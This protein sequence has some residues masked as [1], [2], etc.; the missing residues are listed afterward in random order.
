MGRVTLGGLEIDLVLDTFLCLDGSVYEGRVRVLVR[1]S[2][3][4]LLRGKG[5]SWGDEVD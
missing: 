5:T 2:L 1:G 3:R 4:G